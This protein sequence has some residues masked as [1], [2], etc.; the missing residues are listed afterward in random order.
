MIIFLTETP[1]LKESEKL[2]WYYDQINTLIEEL[3]DRSI[4]EEVAKTISLK[5]RDMN[6]FSG[7][8]RQLKSLANKNI[9]FIIRLLE[10]ELDLVNKNHYRNLW[11][12][13]G[14][15]VF[16]LPLGAAFGLAIGNLAFL[17]IGLPIGMLIG[18]AIGTQ[19]DK[20][21]AEE[22]KQLKFELKS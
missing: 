3:N 11:M 15:S 1:L 14:M 2:S 13:L 10:K 18:L 22:G 17:G 19:K 4:P 16:G 8:A 21:A 5:I 12:A 9:H 20:K 6:Q 7:S